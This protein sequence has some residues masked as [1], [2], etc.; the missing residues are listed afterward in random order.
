MFFYF[1]FSLYWVIFPVVNI[2]II[3]SVQN[4]VFKMRK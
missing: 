2:G 4:E 3:G 1:Y